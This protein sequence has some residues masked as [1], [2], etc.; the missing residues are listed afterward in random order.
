MLDFLKRTFINEDVDMEAGDW[1]VDIII[2]LG[3]FGIALAQLSLT[4]GLIIPDAFTRKMLGISVATPSM[5]GLLAIGATS[6]PLIF[7][8]KFSW[9]CFIFCLISWA[10]LSFK[11]DDIAVSMLPLLV[12]L[13]SLCA[14]R[15]LEDSFVAALLA[16]L[17][18]GFVP[19]L[20]P[21]SVLSNLT[22]IQ[23]L[24]LVFAGAGVGIAFKTTR[25]LVDSAEL[26]V[27]QTEEAA[28]ANTAKRLEEERVA[29][30]RELH[31]I[32]A[33]SLSAISIQAAAAEAQIDN[34]PSDAKET[35]AGIRNIAKGSLAEIRQMIGVLREPG[36]AENG[37]DL[38]PA[39]GTDNLGDISDYLS[40]AQI[41]CQI[42]MHNYD[43]QKTPSFVDI[44]IFGICR[45]AATNIVKHAQADFVQIDIEIVTPDLPRII[46]GSSCKCYVLLSVR[47]NGVG[48]G[49]N[50]SKTSGHGV[51]GMRERTVALGGEFNIENAPGGGTLL[52]AILPLS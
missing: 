18:V 1:L 44:A 5:F 23:N 32:T 37:P 42:N 38:V 43:K 9:A 15:P 10:F 13:V 20:T 11:G 4:A 8:R 2:A 30:A 24:S 29:I 25:D 41:H 52:T 48:L 16:F 12:S 19:S 7:R 50:L 49:E 31:D 34:S 27:R 21:H 51:E 46:R 26:R 22:M 39:L 35:I 40:N 47:D 3:V 28:K 6:L 36:D 14:M 45:E 17:V 33:H